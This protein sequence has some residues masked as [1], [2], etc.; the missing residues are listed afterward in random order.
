MFIAVMIGSLLAFITTANGG[1]LTASRYPIALSN[2]NM[3]PT[4][5]SRTSEKKGTPYVAIIATGALIG[6]AVT[7]KLDLL[8]KAASAVILLSNIFAHLSVIV[9]RESRVA[10]YRPTFKAP[11]YPW[12]QIAGIIAFILLIVDMGIQ[13][14][15]ISLMF[16]SAGVVLYFSRRSKSELISPALAHLVRRITNK[17]LV[18]GDLSSE[19]KDI[20]EDRDGIVRDEFDHVVENSTYMEIEKPLNVEELWIRIAEELH[21]SLPMHSREEI[22]QL[23]QQREMDGSTAISEFVAVPHIISRGEKEF[24]IIFVRAPEGIYFSEESP[25]VKAV[26]VLI[27]TKDMRRLHLRALAAIAQVVQGEHFEE[28]WDAARNHRELRDLFHLSKRKRNS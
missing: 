20:V 9:M 22:V 10:N 25:E 14:I 6:I 19:L 24:K 11:L 3:L 15:L 23:L 13:P 16:I 26:F 2:D 7:L 18:S 12:L 1:I 28:R 17:E 5:F 27:G 4:S 8:V 21:N